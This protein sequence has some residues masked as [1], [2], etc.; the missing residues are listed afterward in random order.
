MATGGLE[1]PCSHTNPLTPAPSADRLN[2]MF[3]NALSLPIG[4]LGH[5]E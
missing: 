4:K 5:L 2:R 3:V 1:M